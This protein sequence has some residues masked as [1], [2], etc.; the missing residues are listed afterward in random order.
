M[1]SI[2][3]AHIRYRIID[4][5]LRNKYRPFPSIEDLRSTCEDALFGS[6]NGS[7]ISKSTIEKDLFNMREEMDAP[8][9]YNKSQDGYYY[10]NEDFSINDIPLSEEEIESLKF[11]TK[12]LM[13]FKDVTIFQQFGLAIDKIFDKINTNEIS[14]NEEESIVQ[15][16]KAFS[17]SGNEF[18]PKILEAIKENNIIEFYYTSF[19]TNI[20]KKR[21]VKPLL[22]KEYRN[23]WYLISYDFDKK[24]IITYSLDRIKNLV[25]TNEIYLKPIQFSASDF[26][27]Y[28]TGITAGSGNIEKVIFETSII[29]S[30]YIESQPFHSSQKIVKKSSQFVSFEMK[31]LISEEL[32]RDF[33]S[34]GKDIVVLAPE[35]LRI[36]LLKRF[37]LTLA[38]YDHPWQNS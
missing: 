28:S 3:N 5:C 8:I 15:F 29:A 21:S 36:E 38:N 35:T 14:N 37:K 4:R 23:R 16:D 1:P 26:F 19:I 20:E 27:K 7:H 34:Y 30:K 25:V 6:D 11:A 13:Q 31:V 17:H 2:K 33:L 9:K 22:L 10:I 18:L 12:T 24:K 32:I